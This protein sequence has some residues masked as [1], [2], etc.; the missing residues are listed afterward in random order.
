[1]SQT[2]CKV[3]GKSSETVK[4]MYMDIYTDAL[5]VLR[6]E[7]AVSKYD[8]SCEMSEVLQTLHPAHCSHDN[9]ML[10]GGY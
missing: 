5:D 7:L 10:E 3:Q 4:E 2:A 6:G 9:L 8:Q 1:M